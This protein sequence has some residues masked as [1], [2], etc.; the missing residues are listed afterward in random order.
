MVRIFLHLDSLYSVQ[1]R[2]NS[3]QNNFK[4]GLFSRS[5]LLMKEYQITG[6]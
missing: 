4:Y 2:E 3:D 6:R 1:M 5:G